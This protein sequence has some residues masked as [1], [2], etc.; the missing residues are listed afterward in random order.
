MEVA[1]RDVD[2]R[3]TRACRLVAAG[4]EPSRAA[5]VVAALDKAVERFVGASQE[6][7]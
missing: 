5:G 3:D 4:D 7:V 6:A 1:D 2:D